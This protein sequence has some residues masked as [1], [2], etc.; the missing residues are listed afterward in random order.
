MR[1]RKMRYQH[2]GLENA[3]LENGGP[4]NLGKQHCMEQRVFLMCAQSC[5]RYALYRVPFYLLKSF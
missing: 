1:Y 4:G 2:A 3:G 5:R